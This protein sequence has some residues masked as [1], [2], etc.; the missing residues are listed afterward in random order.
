M[1]IEIRVPTLGESVTEATVGKWFKKA[2]EA[3]KVD[4]PLVELETDK[5][6]VEVPAPSSGVMGE[7]FVAQG[8]TVAVGSLLAALKDGAA[9]APASAPKPEVPAPRPAAVQAQTP[10]SPMPT[11]P[12]ARKAMTEAGLDTDDVAGSGRRGQVLKGDVISAKSHGTAST[13]TQTE[14]PHVQAPPVA[15]LRPATNT[16]PPQQSTLTNV[17]L[18]DARL[19]SAGSLALLVRFRHPQ[20]A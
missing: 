3:V 12:A 18:R 14:A 16:Q 10:R 6:T 13:S 1:S 11:S 5:V 8:S 19:P 2:G 17:A 4:E 7:I 9:A 20:A 15:M